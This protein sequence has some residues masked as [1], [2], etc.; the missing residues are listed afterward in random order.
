MTKKQLIS[1]CRV[2]NTVLDGLE[3]KPFHWGQ[4]E[5]WALTPMLTKIGITIVTRTQ[6]D[7][8]GYRLKRSQKPVGT[9]YF[10]TPINKNADIYVLEIQCIKI[11]D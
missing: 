6:I 10:G 5:R 1:L 7:K 11:S 4:G 3:G 9:T 8:C 2:I